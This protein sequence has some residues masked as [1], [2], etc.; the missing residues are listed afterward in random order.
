MLR[1]NGRPPLARFRLT[2]RAPYAAMTV[3]RGALR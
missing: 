2:W 1:M 3:N